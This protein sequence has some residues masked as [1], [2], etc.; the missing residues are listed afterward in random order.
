MHQ[1]LAV[2]VVEAE[3][4][5][6]AADEALVVELQALR[7]ARLPQELLKPQVRVKVVAVAEAV[8]LTADKLQQQSL[9]HLVQWLASQPRLLQVPDAERM[10]LRRLRTPI[11]IV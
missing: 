8:E 5:V 2:V 6:D 1:A 7:Q 11:R 4:V 10:Q 3:A 9:Q